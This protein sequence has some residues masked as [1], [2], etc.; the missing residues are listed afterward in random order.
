MRLGLKAVL[1]SSHTAK[2]LKYES[3]AAKKVGVAAILKHVHA[4][5]AKPCLD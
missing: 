4:L 3:H 2:Q 1:P 5:T